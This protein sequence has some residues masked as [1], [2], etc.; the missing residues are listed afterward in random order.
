MQ[1]Q[2]RHWSATDG[3]FSGV[4]MCNLF[5]YSYLFMYSVTKHVLQ[6]TDVI[7][8]RMWLEDM[9]P[10]HWQIILKSPQ[11]LLLIRK[12]IYMIRDYLTTCSASTEL[13]FNCVILWTISRANTSF[14]LIHE[15]FVYSFQISPL[16]WFGPQLLQHHLVAS[17]QPWSKHWSLHFYRWL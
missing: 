6:A 8:E 16:Y 11:V 15:H 10:N 17:S 13:N 3:G 7:C 4:F 12:C 2:Y 14:P 1:P 9:F 5:K